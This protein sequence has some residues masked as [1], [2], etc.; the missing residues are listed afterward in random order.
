[1]QVILDSLLR[2]GGLDAQF[3]TLADFPNAQEPEE[4]GTTYAENAAI[5]AEAAVAATGLV[6]IADDAGLEIAA[7]DGAPGLH[8]KRFGGA[9]LPFS[10]KIRRVLELLQ[11]VPEDARSARFRCA[12]A[13]AAPHMP[14]E[15]F[16]A[17]CEGRIARE[18]RGTGGFGYDPIFLYPPL[19]R[20]FAELTPDDKNSVSHRGKV[21][22]LVARHLLHCHMSETR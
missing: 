7:L 1:M 13:V 8:S 3:V 22:Q 6:C 2:Q 17:T 20:T 19:G 16:E 11:D 12:V 18:P 5:K 14:T 9:D 10:D 21:L 15:V 4:V